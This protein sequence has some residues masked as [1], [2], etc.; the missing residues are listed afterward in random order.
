MLKLK[1][2]LLE[3]SNRYIPKKGLPS[4]KDIKELQKVF[5]YDSYSHTGKFDKKTKRTFSR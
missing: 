4:I 2:I 5:F 3:Q 1:N